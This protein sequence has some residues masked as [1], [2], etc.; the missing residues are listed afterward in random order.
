MSN[1]E[2][3]FNYKMEIRKAQ[4]DDAEQIRLL[5]D[6]PGYPSKINK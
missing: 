4:L 5:S 3:A 6:E 1:S 2:N